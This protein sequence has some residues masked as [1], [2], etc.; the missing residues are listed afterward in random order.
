[1]AGIRGW[2]TSSFLW[3]NVIYIEYACPNWGAIA[4]FSLFLF[5]QNK[6]YI[7][8]P[9]K[10]CNRLVFFLFQSDDL[11]K[12][13]ILAILIEKAAY[14]FQLYIYTKNTYF[15]STK[16]IWT[17]I[18]KFS[19]NTRGAF[20]CISRNIR[21][22][23][24]RGENGSKWKLYSFFLHWLKILDAVLNWILMGEGV[25]KW[26]KKSKFNKKLHKKLT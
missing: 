19:M 8:K 10:K 5:N 26:W 20:F 14:N 1:M 15:F 6:I 13:S 17:D 12:V 2:K 22:G 11:K 7:L 25:K 24:S 18:K 21:W 23:G 16:N 4:T 9:Y 3:N